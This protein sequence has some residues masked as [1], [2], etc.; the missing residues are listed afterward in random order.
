MIGYQETTAQCGNRVAQHFRQ[1]QP[2]PLTIPWVLS[3]GVPFHVRLGD[4]ASGRASDGSFLAGLFAGPAY[5]DSHGAAACIKVNFT[6]PGAYRF[7]GVPMDELAGRLVAADELLGGAAAALSA[8]LSGE[9]AWERR[10]DLIE[11][12]LSS[13][14]RRL[15]APPL[16][17]A[18][19]FDR[20]L[21]TGGA[22]PI[23]NLAAGLGWSRKHLAAKF[24]HEIGLTPKTIARMARFNRVLI[25]A[26]RRDPGS[27]AALAAECCYA[28]QAHLVRD[29]KDFTGESPT[30]WQA[31]LAGRPVAPMYN[32]PAAR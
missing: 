22:E 14:V 13:R 11:A 24:R 4:T 19:A 9:P 12:F 3:F 5:V 23:S 32:P 7:F 16:P 29:F 17:T 28:D 27:W 8:R 26:R 2:A 25:R 30:A 15:D 31:R 6:A 21:G 18:R 1:I 20:L 10:F